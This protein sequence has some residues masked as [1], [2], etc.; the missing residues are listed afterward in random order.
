M[1]SKT[2]CS[3]PPCTCKVGENEEGGIVADG[4]H[5]CSE[6]CREGEGCICPECGC[7][8]DTVDGDDATPVP[9]L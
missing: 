9:M 3:H 8:M 7:R 2:E 4:R 6:G 5:Y 1:S